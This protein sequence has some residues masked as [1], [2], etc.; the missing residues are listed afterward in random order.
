MK[1]S[2]KK[3]AGTRQSAAGGW[4]WLAGGL[5]AA[6][7]ALGLV[8]NGMVTDEPS[9]RVGSALDRI[10][11]LAEPGAQE[12]EATLRMAAISGLPKELADRSVEIRFCPPDRLR[13]AVE[14]DGAEYRIGRKGETIW[15]QVPQKGLAIEGSNAVP[16]FARD[17]DSVVE[18]KLPAFGSPLT[19]WQR[20]LVP[21][22]I[23]ARTG[24]DGRL[25]AKLKPWVAGPLD[26]PGDA[27]VSFR[28]D[29]GGMPREIWFSQGKTELCVAV[30]NLQLRKEGETGAAEWD[31][32]AGESGEVERVS[33]SHLKRFF[34]VLL[35][36]LDAKIPSLP[37]AT[38]ERKVVG[39]HGEGRL[40]VHDGVRV[41]F[42]KGSPEEMGAQQGV[43]LRN[44]VRNL[45]DRIVYGVGVGSSFPKGRWFFGEIE[46][47]QGLLEPFV[48]ERYLREMDA[49]AAAAGVH[50]QEARL[51]NFFPELFHCSGFALHGKATAGGRMFHGR[52]LD[53]LRGLG[54]E[55]NA[56][57][58]V[59]EPDEGNAW[60]NVGYAGFV[61][62][63]T[64]MN[65]K[66]VAIGEMGG[67]G[68]GK[69]QGKPMAQ[70]MREVME[71]ADTID[72]A[73]EILRKGPRTCEYYYVISDAKTMRA[74]GVAAT[75]ETFE[76]VW[77]GESHRL[78]P[79]PVEDAV[80]MSAGDRYT[81]LVR[82]VKEGYG[83]FDAGS[84]RELMTRP[85]CMKSNIQ[86]VLFAP[87]T[88][89]FWVANA[90]S[91]NVA[92]HTRYTEF[93]LRELL[94]R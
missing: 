87:D 35:A 13:I 88:L 94:G 90:D 78:L 34:E 19:A 68:E 24:E 29:D 76:L 53:Y 48:E 80:L 92:S 63:V 26:V 39:R 28:L 11:S 58:M 81:E 14:I 9:R 36:N 52:I 66:Q 45:V 89:D 64:A 42:L 10:C 47:A 72:D 62:T 55:Q 83:S 1:G 91:E 5:A 49:L 54:L 12:V 93:N 6:L 22:L 8:W 32:P 59:V 37:P 82:R 21:A 44:E 15:L 79:E 77:S 50:P 4:K 43:L 84:A 51:A 20:G 17:P 70:L 46:E 86:S 2:G 33:L 57:V 71:R 75:P 74:V 27:E 25:I 85:V 41:L 65:E 40:E 61:G 30:E 16:R 67:R 31:M 23:D 73:V 56:V 7:L 18:V 60:V 3:Q 69:W 38:G